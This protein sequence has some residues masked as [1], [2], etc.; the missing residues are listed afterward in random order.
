MKTN[1]AL[2]LISGLLATTAFAQAAPDT[3]PGTQ[4]SMSNSASDSRQ[5][6]YA[7]EPDNTA[8]NVRDRDS[9]TKTPLDQGGNKTD[10]EITARIRKDIIADKGLSVNARNVKIVTTNGMVTL[11][12]PVNTAEEKQRIGEIA[13]RAAPQ[14]SVDNQLEVK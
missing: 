7:T 10:T 3:T 6:D 5:A 12:G 9:A 11:R 2:L 14:A 13:G 4:D 8:R 1:K